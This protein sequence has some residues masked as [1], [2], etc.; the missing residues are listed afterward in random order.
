MST[1]QTNCPHCSSTVGLEPAEVLVLTSADPS[2]SGTYLFQ[3]AVCEQVVVKPASPASLALLATAGAIAGQP[4]TP[5]RPNARPFTRDD[6]L[7]FHL[8]LAS[9]D[10]L[11]SLIA[12]SER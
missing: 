7:D 10:R 2:G 1:I 12:G 8:L 3:C 11:I 4:A 6:L 9:G 5:A